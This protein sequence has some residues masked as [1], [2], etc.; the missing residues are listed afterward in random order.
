MHDPEPHVE[1]DARRT[2][3]ARA[4]ERM[5]PGPQP[6]IEPICQ[7]SVYA[8][9]DAEQADGWFMSGM[10]TYSRDGLPNVRT[11]E[12]AVADLEGTEDA[13][14]V[15]SGMAAISM[16][17]LTLLRSGQHVV[18]GDDVYCESSSLLETVAIR[19]GIDITR[20][21]LNDA[22]AVEAAVRPTTQLVLAETI[23]NSGMRL[24]DLPAVSAIAKRR[25]VLLAVDN[26]FATPVLCQPAAFGADLVIHSAGKFLSGHSDVTTGVVAG[27]RELILQLRETAHLY[28]P[29]LAPMEAWLATRGMRTLLPR[30]SWAC[31][32][33]C[34]V[35]SWLA[36]QPGV[37]SVSYA[38]LAGSDQAE[39]ARRVLPHGAGAILSF[40]LR[41]DNTVAASFVRGL[42][43]IPYVPSIGGTTTTVSFP[44]RAPSRLPMA[45]LVL[46]WEHNTLRLSLG[47]E[48]P[49]DIIADL[50]YALAT[51]DGAATPVGARRQR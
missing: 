12:R 2:R 43:L 44:P 24:L 7:S 19:F 50:G 9:D 17:L 11:L 5:E 10:P 28:G 6:L 45:D 42:H 26:T 37:V 35:A 8:F 33:A 46:P 48:D 40:T 31:Q 32:S 15:S 1:Q 36:G 4:G 18:I 39:L 25:G 16:T 29:V 21:D 51:I 20:V 3:I 34:R 47:L 22:V 27:S 30:M 38:G 14:A 13:I 41:G 23:S 49:A